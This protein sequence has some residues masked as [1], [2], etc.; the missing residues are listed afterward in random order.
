MADDSDFDLLIEDIL[1]RHGGRD[2]FTPLTLAVARQLATL[3]ASNNVDPKIVLSL[4]DMLP[5]PNETK[6]L[7]LSKF[8]DAQLDQ[9]ERLHRI[10]AG[11]DPP[12]ERDAEEA[13]IAAAENRAHE[14]EARVHDLE[15]RL[16]EALKRGDL[17][18]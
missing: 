16:A 17:A 11:L 2:A 10:G 13:R 18:R 7:D 9:L 4:R 1:E 14:A 6:P 5:K 3:L 12:A 8:S 15:Q